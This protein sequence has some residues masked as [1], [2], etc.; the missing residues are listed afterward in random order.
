MA[1]GPQPADLDAAL[2]STP[3]LNYQVVAVAG[4]DHP[5]ARV[6]PASPQL[7]EQTWL[8]GPSAAADVGVMPGM[9]R[10]INVPEDH[11]QIFQSHAAAARGGQA[12]QR[13]G[14]GGVVRGGARTWPT[15]DLKR[16]PGPSL[17]AQ[18][19]WS[20]LTLAEQHAPPAAAELTRFVTTPRATQAMLRGTGVNVGRFKPSIHVTLWS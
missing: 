7:R 6:Q 2:A 4:P 18:G 16:V 10:R 13:R 14:A 17:Q 11:Q 1:I 20:I 15:A 5:L 19:A 9:L 12:Q 3:F 8:L